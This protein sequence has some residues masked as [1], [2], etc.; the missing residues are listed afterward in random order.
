MNKRLRRQ[1]AFEQLS[2]LEAQE[3]LRREVQKHQRQR[4]QSS[5]ITGVR[6][7]MPSGPRGP[8]RETRTT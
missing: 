1:S 2:Q 8:E 3:L 7:P 5:P 6:T 4:Q